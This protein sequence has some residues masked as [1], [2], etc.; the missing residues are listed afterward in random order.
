MTTPPMDSLAML[1]ALHARRRVLAYEIGRGKTEC[2]P[3]L[4]ATEPE[5]ARVMRAGECAALAGQERQARSEDGVRAREQAEPQTKEERLRVLTRERLA[6][7]R[8]VQAATAR[9]EEAV[10]ALVTLGT[11]TY[12]VASALGR[13]PQD[14][15]RLHGAVEAFLACRLRLGDRPPH[16]FRKPLTELLPVIG[17]P[18]EGPR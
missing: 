15:L 6:A 9:L 1:E 18:S 3:E 12:A 14:K 8:K 2:E 5:I 16:A 11:E 17:P 7:A 10:G 4:D 13:R